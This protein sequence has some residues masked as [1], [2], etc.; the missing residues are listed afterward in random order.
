MAY[1]IR[2]RAV[3]IALAALG[4]SASNAKLK[5]EFS[6]D[7]SGRKH[8]QLK[9]AG[10]IDVHQKAA[11]RPIDAFVLTDAGWTWVENEMGAELP[12]NAGSAG[13]ALYALLAGLRP[14]ARRAGGLRMLLSK[15]DGHGDQIAQSTD[16]IRQQIHNAYRA[17]AK[18]PQDWVQLR[19]LRPKLA[20][21]AKSEVDST[22]KRM[23]L[24]KEINLTLNDDQGALTQADRDAAI[25]IGANDMH[26]LSMG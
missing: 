23:F 8:K 25:R 18:R 12:A 10:K 22:L 26:M 13:G 4:G 5:N 15:S 3:M 17:I 2:E 16:D 11:G 24:D 9:K 14:A 1:G 6:L 7:F 21:A 20:G 19:E